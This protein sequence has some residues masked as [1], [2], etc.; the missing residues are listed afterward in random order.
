MEQLQNN[1]LNAIT[2]IRPL[3]IRNVVWSP[4]HML[5][6]DLKMF[7]AYC[8]SCYPCSVLVVFCMLQYYLKRT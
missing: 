7:V 3:Q 8:Y 4:Y 1:F 5:E 2:G 6:D